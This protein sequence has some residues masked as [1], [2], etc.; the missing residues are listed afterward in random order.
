[1]TLGSQ[2]ITFSILTLKPPG[3]SG[4]ISNHHRATAGT[5]SNYY[6]VTAKS[7]LDHQQAPTRT[8][9][10]LKLLVKLFS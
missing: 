5:P 3:H 7:L 9:S 2:N 10:D 1:M 4:P 6:L 8:L